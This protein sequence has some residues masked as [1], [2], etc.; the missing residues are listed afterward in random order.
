MAL[1]IGRKGRLYLVQ[2][3]GSYGQKQDGT[4]GANTLSAAA[5]GL[6]HIDFKFT[7]DPFN[8]TNSTEKKTSPGQVV[9]FDRRATA[10]LGSLVGLI[11]PSGV[12][13]TL[14]ECAPVFK[15]AFGSVHNLTLA[16]TINDAAATTKSATLASVAGIAVGDA[17]LFVV[18]GK[19][20]VRF[21]TS[22]V[23]SV[24]NWAPALPAAPADASPV[25]GAIT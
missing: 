14:P 13:N 19:K 25:K 6:R 11:R 3:A 1:N 16:T 18:N 5:R 17:L 15:A 24:A 4:N 12:L 2:E 22:V 20:Y 8:R 7:F 10:Q 21:V 23:G 9:T